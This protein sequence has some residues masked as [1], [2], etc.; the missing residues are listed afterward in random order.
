[1]EK[2]TPSQSYKGVCYGLAAYLFWGI[3]PLYWKCM[4]QID[5]FEILAW[6]ILWC[7]AFVASLIA[8][9][10]HWQAFITEI[11]SLLYRHAQLRAVVCAALLISINWGVYIWAVNADHIIDTS[12]GYYINPLVSILLGVI[13]LK[14]RMNLL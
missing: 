11:R 8:V 14:E 13:F 2:S 4:A 9:R 6:R 1:M 10:G 7:G 5:A 12:M 3:M